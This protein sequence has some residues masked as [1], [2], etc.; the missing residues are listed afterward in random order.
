[1]VPR[2]SRNDLTASTSVSK[3]KCNGDNREVCRRSAKVDLNTPRK[4]EISN[5]E[6]IYIDN[7]TGVAQGRDVPSYF[8]QHPKFYRQLGNVTESA[9]SH[10]QCT[11]IYDMAPKAGRTKI[12]R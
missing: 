1:M 10:L 12:T 4:H 8:L 7:L 2:I 5:K 3:D 9:P 11:Q 6:F